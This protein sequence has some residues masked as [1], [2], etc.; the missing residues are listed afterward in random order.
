MKKALFAFAVVAI[1]MLSLATTAGANG[2]QT[3]D[4]TFTGATF[5][6][7]VV[8]NDGVCILIAS[9]VNGN[10]IVK[11]GAY[12][13]SNNS[14]ISGGVT[15]LVGD[16]VFVHDGSTVGGSTTTLLTDNVFLFDSSIGGSANVLG[17]PASRAGRVNVCGMTVGR[18]ITVLFSGT[19]ILVGAPLA[20]GCAGN[21]ARSATV[22][23]NFVD[24]E[25]VVSGNT[26]ERQ[27]E[28]SFNKGPAAKSVE[29]NV[30]TSA[31]SSI[32]CRLNDQPFAAAANLFARAGGQCA[33]P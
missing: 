32:D 3:C 17:T 12:F 14:D 20:V 28:V 16:T 10:V 15:S 26:I 30:G 29:G 13:E 2:T 1:A 31:S 8:P 11:R 21:S 27:L 33:G 24:V 4:G 6:S 23:A 9:Q 22:A 18:D 5:D 7:I 25:L 19:D